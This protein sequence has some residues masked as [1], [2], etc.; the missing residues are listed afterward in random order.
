MTYNCITGRLASW[1]TKAGYDVKNN[2][3][4]EKKKTTPTPKRDKLESNLKTKPKGKAIE[5][6]DRIGLTSV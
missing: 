2:E 5:K 1:I 4:K 6:F 3:K